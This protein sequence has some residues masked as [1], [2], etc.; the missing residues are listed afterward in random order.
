MAWN[1]RRSA[2]GLTKRWSF[3]AR[4]SISSFHGDKAMETTPQVASKQITGKS[5]YLGLGGL[6]SGNCPSF[7]VII[8]RVS[9]ISGT[10]EV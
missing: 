7:F 1:F 10:E 5:L 3:F 4:E 6:R 2:L 8:Q 9:K